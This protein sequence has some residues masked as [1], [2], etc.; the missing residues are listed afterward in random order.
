MK[1]IEPCNMEAKKMQNFIGEE[2]DE[3]EGRK[4]EKMEK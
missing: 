3:G 1:E 4:K 2:E